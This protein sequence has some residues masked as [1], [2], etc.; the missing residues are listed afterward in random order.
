MNILTLAFVS[1]NKFEETN[2]YINK[3][4]EKLPKTVNLAFI[5]D[6]ELSEK[7]INSVNE[8]VML[9]HGKNRGKLR[10]ILDASNKFDTTFVKIIDHDDCIDYRYVQDLE[11]ELK[12][13]SNDNF[14]Y[15]PA[16]K[17]GE[18]SKLFGKITLEIDELEALRNESEDVKWNKIPN[19]QAIY[20]V[21]VLKMLSQLKLS[22][23]NYFNDDLLAISC[24]LVKKKAIKIKTKFYYQYH[25]FGQ[26]SIIEEEKAKSLYELFNNLNLF[27]MNF[28]TSLKGMYSNKTMLKRS[29]NY[30]ER[31][32]KNNNVNNYGSWCKKANDELDLLFSNNKLTLMITIH[33][34]FDAIEYYIELLRGIKNNILFAF[35]NPDVPKSKLKLIE[36][37]G[38]SY[39]V[40][41]TNTGK[42][43]LVL[44]SINLVK[45]EYF[46]IIDQDDSISV[47]EL[48]K[49]NKAI[50]KVS[51]P[52]IIKHKAFKISNKQKNYRRSLDPKI[53]KEQVKH[54]EDVFYNQQTNCDTIYHTKTLEK[55]N[56]LKIKLTRQN[57]HNDVLISNYMVGSGLELK[58]INKG[59]YIQFHEMG[60]TSTVNIERSECILELYENYK[61]LTKKIDGFN[62]GR[63]MR[64]ELIGHR[65]FIDRF[66]NKYLAE[67]DKERGEAL[68]KKTMNIVEEI[69]KIDQ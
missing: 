13:K 56:E 14:Y 20:N 33:S 49:F 39:F 41:K 68:F 61:L 60:Q 47:P 34:D 30:Q 52:L 3:L 65:R 62:I 35:D 12:S 32:F 37:E 29:N 28:S 66:T 31:I 40:N 44:N 51:G 21:D 50:N 6:N 57:F 23:Q 69:W 15:H 54:S 43:K 1:H 64:K 11:N 38:H 42:V 58:V 8:K 17:I 22:R 36:N 24:Q 46:K 45:T 59:F 18:E 4:I 27:K 63:T 10:A 7:Q 5:F 48:Q 25:N 16:T 67:I 19:A 9:F 55:I 26:T 2:V 53:I